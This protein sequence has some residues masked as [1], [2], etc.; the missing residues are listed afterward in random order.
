MLKMNDEF[1]TSAIVV[2][3][4]FNYYYEGRCRTYLMQ[5]LKSSWTVIISAVLICGWFAGSD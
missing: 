2:L 3:S 1:G 5:A 4:T